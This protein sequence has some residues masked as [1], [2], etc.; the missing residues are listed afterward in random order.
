MDVRAEGPGV[1]VV[2]ES[3]EAGWSARVDGVAARLLR[4]EHG[5][6]AVVLPGGFHRLE[7]AHRAPGLTAGLALACL[8]AAV[9]AYPHD[10][11]G[12]R[13]PAGK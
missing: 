10:G 6:M 3:W 13:R 9:L 12:S 11:R 2:A 5:R 1:L 7:L 8:G 4:V